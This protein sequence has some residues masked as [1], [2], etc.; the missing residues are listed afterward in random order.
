MKKWKGLAGISCTALLAVMM[1]LTAFA[2][3]GAPDLIPGYT[4]I[5]F[6]GTVVSVEDGCLT[7]NRQLDWGTDELIV[8]LTDDT[9]ILDAVN[10]YP[11]SVENLSEGEPVRVY[12]GMTMTMSLP[13]ITNGI[14][15]LCDI[16]SDAGFPIYTDVQELKADENG[17][18]ILTTIDGTVVTV[19]DE[20]IL[21]PYLT[22]NIVC[23]EDMIPGTTI[24]LWT[25]VM[26]PS[27][28]GKIVIF[29]GENGFGAAPSGDMM[30]EP[31]PEQGWKLTDEGWYF[32]ENGEVKKGWLFESGDWYYLNPETGLMHTGFITLDGKTYFLK[33]DGRMLTEAHAFTPDENG[34]LHF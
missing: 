33:E 30:M 4:P 24:L 15:I 27:T 13:P 28:A 10:G 2:S 3:N 9:R 22:R 34:E 6:D 23:A 8:Q 25:D 32:F 11:V 29:P 19:N 20:T 26:D 1:G 16:P 31:Q 14:V 17:G 5:P 18:Y 21:M 12:S 7:M